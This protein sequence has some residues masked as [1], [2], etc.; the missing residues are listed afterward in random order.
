MT[1][2]V[3]ATESAIGREILAALKEWRWTQRDLAQV[4]GVSVAFISDI[5]GGHRRI[6]AAMA[7]RLEAA[8]GVSSLQWLEMQRE[9]DAR[10][11]EVERQG[12]LNDMADELRAICQRREARNAGA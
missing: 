5:I 8:L 1:R 6:G 9:A 10:E 3:T 2:R 11:L 4:A 12:L 7:W